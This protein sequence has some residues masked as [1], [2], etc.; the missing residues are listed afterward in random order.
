MD[1]VKW[2]KK[3][4]TLF[5]KIKITIPGKSRLGLKDRISFFSNRFL[6]RFP[7]NKRKPILLGLGGFVMLFLLLIIAALII[8]SGT[9][10]R[11]PG[12]SFPSGK[13]NGSSVSNAGPYIP[14]DDLFIPPEPDFLP[15][16]LLEREARKYWSI[17]D[18][19]PYWKSPGST[20]LWRDEIKPVIDKLMEGVP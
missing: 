6:A 17:E 3:I 15:E 13:Q 19:N 7:E 1:F 10:R 5:S 4:L 20:A 9:F 16:F 2:K 12:S 8:N 11:Y 14:S 18:I